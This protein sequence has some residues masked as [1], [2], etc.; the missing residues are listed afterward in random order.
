[1]NDYR[2]QIRKTIEALDEIEDALH[3]RMLNLAME[4]ELKEVNNNFEI[5]DVVSFKLS[6]FMDLEDPNIKLLMNIFNEVVLGKEKLKNLF[7]DR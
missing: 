2:F 7:P 3:S 6:D 5:D 4:G 1:M